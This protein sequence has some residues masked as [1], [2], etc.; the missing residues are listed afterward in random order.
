MVIGSTVLLFFYS[1]MRHAL[2]QSGAFDLGFFDQALYLISRGQPPIISFWGYHVLGGHA[3]W[4]LYLLAPL[5]RLAAN[6][7]WLFAIQA[8]SLAIAAL[9]LY[10]LALHA[11]LQSVQARTMAAVYLLYPLVFNL[12]LF[13]FHPEVMALPLFFAVVLAARQQRVGWFALGI[14]FILGCRA[15][16]SLTVAAMGIWLLWFERRRLCGAIALLAGST[17]FILATQVVI[18]SF[19]PGGVE[20][21]R[22]YTFLG[23][24]VLEIVQNL[25]LKPDLI[26]GRVFS[27]GTL[28]YL[29]LLLVP[30]FWGL[31]RQHLAPL[32][33]ALPSLSINILSDSPAQRDLVHQYSLPI[34]PFLLLAMMAAWADGK[35]WFHKPRTILLW[36]LIGFLALAKY[37]YLGTRY[38][39]SLDTWAATKEA[40]ALVQTPGSVLTTHELVPHLTHRTQVNYPNNANVP[41]SDPSQF[42]Y[43]LLNLRHPGWVNTAESIASI[44]Q[45]LQTT[46]QFTLQYQRDDVY[47]FVNL[48]E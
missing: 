35:T 23:N 31:S 27:L 39:R 18:P 24:S 3:D 12:N 25:F 29:V 21:V 22:R 37:S 28:E 17:W 15:A 45:Q 26:L 5:Y 38:L 34:L 47:L 48:P 13:D 46:P 10:H 19:R 9:P 16:L 43:I 6:V 8:V 4:I 36:S 33:V 14:L 30:V 42:D 1:S 11:G 2:F 20:S 41:I 40:I 32:L 44:I 7:H